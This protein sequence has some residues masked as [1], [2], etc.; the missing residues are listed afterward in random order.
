MKLVLIMMGKDVTGHRGHVYEMTDKR[1]TQIQTNAE[2]QFMY[3][4]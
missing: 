4:C 3:F 2:F 1:T